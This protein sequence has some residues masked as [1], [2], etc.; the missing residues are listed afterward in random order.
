MTP[1]PPTKQIA[2]AGGFFLRHL[3]PNA[4]NSFSERDRV[5][6]QNC[7]PETKRTDRDRCIDSMKAITKAIEEI[8]DCKMPT[9]L[10]DTATVLLQQARRIVNEM[11]PPFEGNKL[12]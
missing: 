1:G 9:M 2:G 8:G 12:S 5:A 10:H 6:C 7:D 4:E 3:W 11:I